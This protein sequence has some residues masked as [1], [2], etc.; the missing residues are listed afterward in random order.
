[1]L[2]Y[3]KYRLPFKQPFRSAGKE[4]AYREGLILVFNDGEVE[5][6]GEVAP[7]PGFSN[8]TLA[9]VTEVLKMNGN[10]LQETIANGNGAETLKMLDQIHHFPSLG[11]GLD[12][13]LHD[14]EA[15]KKG[16]SLGD[17]LFKDFPESVTANATLP[18]NET[19]KTLTKAKSLI[20][21]GFETLKV[22][23]GDDFETE[24]NL[25]QDL[26]NQ[27]PDIK[28]RI[29]ANQAW[30]QEEAIKHLKTLQALDIEYCE[31]PVAEDRI[32]ELAMVKE[33]SEIPIAADESIRNKEQA[34]ELSEKKAADL[35]V[36]KPMLLGTF[37]NIFVT[38][39]TSVTHNIESI[40]TTSL[41]S[42]VGRAV[43]ATFAAG[44]GRKFRAQGLAT[45]NLFRHD[46]SPA[47]WLNQ[48]VISFPKKN[49]L[50][51]KLDLEGLKKVF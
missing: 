27:F 1:M 3:Y 42:A 33:N 51:I 29:D 49:G 22:K 35:F 20:E 39:R 6:Y 45:G 15:K 50:G 7:L 41:E 37:D 18:L 30:N 31:Q 2:S 44:L 34:T 11:F 24:L 9:Q 47:K 32:A 4:F 36:L 21:Q 5:A 38:N 12:T 17:H 40:F 10:H 19:A 28:I 16:I 48:P 14:L 8:E 25:L 13:L 23:V 46:V 26:R 43:I